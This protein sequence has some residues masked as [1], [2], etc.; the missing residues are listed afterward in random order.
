M[1]LSSKIMN[2]V[3]PIAGANFRGH[4]AIKGKSKV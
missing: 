4:G 1:R 3:Y 2:L